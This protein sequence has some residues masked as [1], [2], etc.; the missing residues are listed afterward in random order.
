MGKICNEI[1]L[2][3]EKSA[4]LE[5]NALPKDLYFHNLE[6]TMQVVSAVWEIGAMEN[7]K[8]HQIQLVE[9]AAW[10]HDTGHKTKYLGHESESIAIATHYL[11]LLKVERDIVQIIQGCIRATKMPQKANNL[12]QKIICDA[13]LYHLSTKECLAK[14]QL[15]RREFKEK[16]GREVSD[17]CWDRTNLL[18][19]KT[20][21]YFTDYGRNQ[22]Q[23]KKEEYTLSVLQRQIVKNRIEQTT[24]NYGNKKNNVLM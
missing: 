4:R 14:G 24:K 11:N 13:D 7:L 18:F 10:F 16:L 6:H 21:N 19:L 3:L 23:R 1:A 5:L 12:F 17:E 22:L 15:L 2:K 9:I 8:T 20:H